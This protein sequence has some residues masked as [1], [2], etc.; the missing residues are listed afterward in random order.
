MSK[1][2]HPLFRTGIFSDLINP[3]Q[4]NLRP[5]KSRHSLLG[6]PALELETLTETLLR[7]PQNQVR[8]TTRRLDAGDNFEETFRKNNGNKSLESTLR[9]MLSTDALIMV[10]SPEIDP[11]FQPIYEQIMGSVS[12]LVAYRDAKRRILM[13]TL[14]LFLASP[15]SVTP[16]HLDRYSTFLFQFRGTKEVYVGHP[17][18]SR[19]V[20]NA[21]CEAYVSYANTQLPW[22]DERKQQ[23]EH[24][25]F[26]PGEALHIPFVSGHFV[27]N[28]PEDISISL[29]VIFN[30]E[31]TMM[32]RR[33]LNFNHRARRALKPLK[34]APAPVGRNALRDASKAR[35]W[36]TFQSARGMEGA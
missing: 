5:F 22:C 2:P 27:K 11:I 21:D 31:Q 24:F 16:F 26:Q 20:S 18:D 8:Y 6:D 14:Y 33:A 36:R 15:N 28:G 1:L 10:N 7:L 4:L 3:A 13:P 23:L 32:W 19:V 17:W 9:N 25:H 29:S 12:E 34:V 30:T 35:L